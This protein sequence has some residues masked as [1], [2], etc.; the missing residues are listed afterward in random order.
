MDRLSQTK[1]NLIKGLSLENNPTL[2]ELLDKVNLKI[3]EKFWDDCLFLPLHYL[4]INTKSTLFKRIEMYPVENFT[5]ED[6]ESFVV[7]EKDLKPLIQMSRYHKFPNVK[8]EF[9]LKVMLFHL[10]NS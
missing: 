2:K 9:I 10:M 1:L 8:T 7:T 5:E 4:K 3:K 6:V